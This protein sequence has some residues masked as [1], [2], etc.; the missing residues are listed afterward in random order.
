MSVIKKVSKGR[1]WMPWLSE[2]M[3]DVISCDKLGVQITFDPKISE[4]GN[5]AGR[6]PVIP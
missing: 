4:W 1:R 6:R 3:K 2:A 5:P